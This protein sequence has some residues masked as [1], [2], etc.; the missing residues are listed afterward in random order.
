MIRDFHYCTKLILKKVEESDPEERNQ[1]SRTETKFSAFT[2]AILKIDLLA[3]ASD[4]TNY[5]LTQS[6]SLD[7]IFFHKIIIT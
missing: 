1:K 6:S 5:G 2:D 7:Y 4:H 3:L